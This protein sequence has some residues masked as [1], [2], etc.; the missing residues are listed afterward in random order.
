MDTQIDLLTTYLQ[1][2][3]PQLLSVIGAVGASVVILVGLVSIWYV[4]APSLVKKIFGHADGPDYDH[5]HFEG[6]EDETDDEYQMRV[7]GDIR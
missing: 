2:L 3:F 4:L 7:Y 1:N 6:W 5:D